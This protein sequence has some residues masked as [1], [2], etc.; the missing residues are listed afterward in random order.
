MDVHINA[1][2]ITVTTLVGQRLNLVEFDV[3]R[4]TGDLRERVS[5]S[6]TV[7]NSGPT[8]LRDVQDAATREAIALLQSILSQGS[9]G[10]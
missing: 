5:I 10:A 6:L 8:T 4:T 2:K 1:N 9:A 3:L 7:P